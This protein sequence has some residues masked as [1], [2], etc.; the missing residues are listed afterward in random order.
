MFLFSFSLTLRILFSSISCTRVLQVFVLQ[1]FLF[2][3]LR[4]QSTFFNGFFTDKQQPS[5]FV[6]LSPCHGRH[7][8]CSNVWSPCGVRFERLSRVSRY[9]LRR[10]FN[11]ILSEW[12]CKGWNGFQHYTRDVSDISEEIF[13]GAF[14]LPLVGLTNL[15]EIPKDLVFDAR[16]IFSDSGEQVSTSCKKRE[17]K[18]EFRL[19]SD[20]LVKSIFVKAGS[21]DAVTH[22]RFLLMAA[23]TGGV[24]INWG[25]LLFNIFKEMVTAGSRQAK[26]YA[27]Q[28]C[29]LLKD[30]PAL[31]LGDS[32]AFP[33]PRI[34]TDKTVNRYVVINEKV[35]V[36][37]VANKPRVKRTPVKKAVS[38]KRPATA[39]VVEPV[40]SKKKRT[41]VGKADKGSVLITVAQD[42]VPLKIVEPTPAAPAEQPPVPKRKSKKRRLRL[43]KDSDDE[44]VKE[45]GA[46]EEA[47]EN[48]F[49]E[50]RE[51]TSASLVVEETIVGG[52]TEK[53]SEPTVENAPVVKSTAEEVRTTS[54]DDVDL[55]I[56]QVIIETVQNETDEEEQN[57]GGIDVE[58]T[59]FSGTDVGEQT[60]P[61]DEETDQW[62]NLSYEE[63]IAQE[64]D[65]P[66]VT[67]SDIDEEM[68]TVDFGTGVGEHQLQIF[69]EDE[70]SVDASAAYIV[71][72]PE[73][74]T[75]KDRGT[76]IPHV[77]PA[78]ADK[79]IS[80]QVAA[81]D[82][83]T[84]DVWKEVIELNAKV[85]DLDGK[86]S[87]IRSEL[88]DFHAKAEENHNTLSTQLGFLVDYINRG[89]NDK[90]GE[91]SSS[92]RPQPPPDDQNKPSG[93]SGSR[94]DDPSRYG[95]GTISRESGSQGR[96]GSGESRS[97]GDRS[98]SSKRRR[99][100]VV[101]RP[102]VV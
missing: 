23:I 63:F 56:E 27:I 4:T 61:R 18:I 74:E 43:H 94:S 5:R 50:H 36:E 28:I 92:R 73:A 17:I 89:G 49:E 20:I 13:A 58:G 97:R 72:E 16:S 81:A 41:K 71:T 42:V 80:T 88:L 69:D 96:S 65:R 87:T 70:S 3:L 85:T 1:I 25:R 51:A 78:A 98:G 12:I 45:R 11:R 48:I 83:D 59:T 10:C 68:E 8:N 53:A 32:K 76:D 31:E 62:F 38:R 77:F 46:V 100:V 29:V 19:L 24:Q 101:N 66:F 6:R 2:R 75:V 82:F 99:L 34:L 84:V 102:F 39:E 64:A 26:G 55:I 37:E 91:D 40:V 86:V 33:S 90:K 35:T 67:A 47:V 60:V 52:L 15:S 7:W 30:V 57:V 54:A 9:L 44:I 93:G 22:E 21:F 14:A 79:R 95:G